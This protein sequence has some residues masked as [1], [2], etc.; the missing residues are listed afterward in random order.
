MTNILLTFGVFSWHAKATD[1]IRKISLPLSEGM[2]RADIYYLYSESPKVAVLILVPGVNENGEFFLK[3]Q[4]WLD[5]A[6]ENKLGLV[7]LSFASKN[8]DIENGNGYYYPEKGSGHL[9]LNGLRQIGNEYEYLPLLIYGFSG[10]AH[11]TSRF[12][13]WQPQKIKA[14][15]AYSAAWWDKPQEHETTPPGIIAC[16]S[17]DYRL[18]ASRQYFWE[19][20]EKRK[21]WLWVELKNIDH[22]FTLPFDEFIRKYFST[23]LSFCSPIDYQSIGCWVDIYNYKIVDFDYKAMYPCATGWLPN[24][25]LYFQ[26]KRLSEEHRQ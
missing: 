19:G 23:I 16:G 5:F 13:E 3:S 14:W 12:V 20:R 21:P 8:E 1:E 17:R 18:E 24:K 25:N 10:G 26:W 9:L 15:V 11:F 4:K 2:T 22:V 6:R 7:A